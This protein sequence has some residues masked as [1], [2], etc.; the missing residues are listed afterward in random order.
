M[1]LSERIG[2][3][4]PS[5]TLAVSAKAKAM[6]AQG[7]DVVSF[8]AGEPDFDTPNHIK[9][10]AIQ[11]IQ[12][13]FTKYTPAS[14]IDEL[15]KAVCEKFARDNGLNFDKS[16]IVISCGGKHAF[17]NLAQVLLDPGDEA[18]IPAPYWVSYPD[19]VRLADGT[20]V[21]LTTE[22]RNGFKLTPQQLDDAIT[23]RTKI[24]L[25]N[26][27]SNPTGA[28]YSREELEALAE[29]ILNYPNAH[30]ISDEIYEKII[31]D[32]STFSS[33]AQCGEEIFNRTIIIHGVSKTYAMTGWRIGFTAG[34]AEIIKAVSMLQSQSTSN[35]TSIAQKA[36]VAAL[37]G[38]QGAVEEMRQAY[39][40]RRDYIVPRLNG[41]NGVTCLTPQGAF[42][43]FP[44]FR[45]W[46]GKGYGTYKINS[47]YDLATYLLDEV[48]VA[49]VPGDAFGAEGYLRLSFATSMEEIKKGLDRIEEGLGK[50]S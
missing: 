39:Q 12:G 20:P 2:R 22:E 24:V 13:G 48:K 45:T 33:I 10:A 29:V 6:K 31:Y 37:N 8:G 42:Y 49:V 41:M 7:I 25:L 47:G 3:I 44:N 38:P 5:P 32:G 28:A 11:A 27:P 50:L 14:G 18:I 19:M 23:D 46:M 4:K 9:E 40:E 16:Q 34:N 17:Y 1:G 43:A 35:P 26:S 15:K 36:A 30:V 21:I